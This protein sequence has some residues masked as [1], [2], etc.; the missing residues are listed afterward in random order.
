[1]S[2]GCA[3]TAETLRSGS[4]STFVSFASR[5]GYRTRIQKEEEQEA[6][7]RAGGIKSIEKASRETERTVSR[8]AHLQGALYQT[9]AAFSATFHQRARSTAV[10]VQVHKPS[11]SDTARSGASTQHSPAPIRVRF[12]ST[13]RVCA[14]NAATYRCACQFS[15][16]LPSRS[17]GHPGST[18]CCQPTLRTASCFSCSADVLTCCRLLVERKIIYGTSSI[19]STLCSRYWIRPGGFGGALSAYR[20]TARACPPAGVQRVQSSYDASASSSATRCR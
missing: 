16:R 2:G 7:A 4:I 8:I 10:P 13:I 18:S 5:A 11:G 15:K 9:G 6:K 1:M 19:S 14:F 12:L 17:K 3:Q 20:T